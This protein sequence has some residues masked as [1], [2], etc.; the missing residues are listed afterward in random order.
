MNVWTSAW[1]YLVDEPA[2]R[3]HWERRNLLAA[4]A[5]RSAACMALLLL[6]LNLLF[7]A[8]NPAFLF[9]SFPSLRAIACLFLCMTMIK[10][11]VSDS[12][13]SAAKYLSEIE[14]RHHWERRNLLAASALRSAAWVAW[15]TAWLCLVAYAIE[16]EFFGFSW[17][18]V[19]AVA[20]LA[21]TA[22]IHYRSFRKDSRKEPLPL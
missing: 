6:A 10:Y 3:Y 5:L 15:R 9:P 21:M 1:K 7:L 14:C 4:T 2:G 20:F 8:F 12:P 22:A 18:W 13:S 17:L 11:S 16:A 19:P